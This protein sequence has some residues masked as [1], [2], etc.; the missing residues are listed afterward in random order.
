M[1]VRSLFEAERADL[2]F[3]PEGI[4]N[5]HMDVGQLGYSEPRGRAF[6]EE[7]ER[8]VRTTPGVEDT[9][10][11]FTIPMGY[12][13]VSSAVEAEGQP[14]ERHERLSAGKNIVS[15]DYF[16]TMGVQIVRGRSFSDRDTG[17]S[18]PVAVVNQHLANMLWPR[19]DAIGQRFR[20]A[21]QERSWV[22]VVGVTETGMYRFLFEDPQPYFYVPIVQEYTALRVL[23]IR[24][25]M[26]PEALTPVIERTIRAL[27]HN[28]P[29]YDVQTMTQALGSG[30]GFFPVR[31]GA[32][33]AASLGLLALALAGIGL[34]GVVSYFTSQRTHEIGVR[35]AV[36]ADRHDILRL[37]LRDSFTLVL[38][39]VVAGLLVT[40][41]CSRLVGS[42]LFGVSPRDP[43]TLVGPAAILGGVALIACAIPAWRA[44]RV[45]PTVALR[46]E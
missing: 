42:F 18:R 3:R 39:G 35:M 10:F 32:V 2:G 9:S 46:A 31:V 4:L 25:S 28:L 15:S 24:T 16:Q 33:S 36:G 37:V 44:A 1:L 43:L 13:R 23:Q 27:E 45:D 6:F 38:V 40:L 17:Q 34:Y 26:R 11:A 20:S 22:E 21:G 30:L 5:I 14:L 8:R 12:I 29:L 19:R 41:V 7:V